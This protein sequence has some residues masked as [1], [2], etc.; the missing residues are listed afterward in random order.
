MMTMRTTQRLGL[1]FL[2]VWLAMA[3]GGCGALEQEEGDLGTVGLA[4]VATGSDGATYRL[5]PGTLIALRREAPRF[6][7]NQSLDGDA[8]VVS[9]ALPPGTYEAGLSHDEGYTTS[10][11]LERTIDGVTTTVTA[12]LLTAQ[13]VTVT[14]LPN[15]PTSLVFDFRVVT[16]PRV[17]FDRGALDVSIDADVV[18]ATSFDSSFTTSDLTVTAG[19][20]DGPWAAELEAR[21]PPVGTT[22]LSVSLA[23]QLTGP[24]QEVG[25]EA[26]NNSLCAPVNVTTNLGAGSAGFADLIAEAGHGDAPGYLF[27]PASLCVQDD[28]ISNVIR[29]RTSRVG[30]GETNTFADLTGDFQWSHVFLGE[31]TERVYD[32]QGATFDIEALLQQSG[33]LVLGGFARVLSPADNTVWYTANLSGTMSFSFV[34]H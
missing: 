12:E 11:P 5:T 24:F 30:L 7:W 21:L 15:S 13:P 9:I 22:G 16:G 6:I 14:V 29:F 1:G 23:V 19:F 26:S 25:G 2:P 27:G 34:G 4:I 10:W 17:T 33:T 20:V 32:F 3:A 31:L 8:P 28:G 18:T